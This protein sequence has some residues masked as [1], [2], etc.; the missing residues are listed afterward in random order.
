MKWAIMGRNNTMSCVGDG[1]RLVITNPNAS[2]SGNKKK[3]VEPTIEVSTLTSFD[4]LNSVDNDVEF[5]T[6]GR[7]TNLVNNG[8][9]SS[10]SFSMNIVNDV[11]FASNT[12]IGEKIDKTE[13]QI[14]EGKLRLLDNDGNPLVPTGIVKSDSK[15]EVIFDETANLRISTS[16][17][18]ESDKGYG[19]NSFL[20]Q[21]RDSYP[22]ND[23]YEPYDDDIT[24]SDDKEQK[25]GRKKNFKVYKAT[26]RSR[27]KTSEGTSKSPQT[28]CKS[29]T[30][31][32]NSGEGCL[33]SP[34]WTKAKITSDRVKQVC[35]FRLYAS[36]IVSIRQ[37][38]RAKQ[39]ALFNFKRGLKEH[40]GRLWEY[41]QDILDSNLGLDGYPSDFQELELRKGHEAYGVNIHLK[42]VCVGCG[43][44]VSAY[45][46]LNRDLV[47]G[48]DHWVKAQSENN[49]QVSRAGRMMTC[50]N[51]QNR[52]QQKSCKRESMPKPPKA[53]KA[54][55]LKHPYYET[56]ASAR[57]E[58]RGSGGRGGM[59]EWSGG[60]GESSAAM[61]EGNDGM[62]QRAGERAQR[63]RGRIK[64]VVERVKEAG[65]GAREVGEG[66]VVTMK[67]RCKMMREVEERLREQMEEEEW[68]MKHDYFHPS[69]W[70]QKESFDHAPFNRRFR[71]GDFEA[72][73]N[74]MS[75][76]DGNAD[77]GITC[78]QHIAAVSPSVDKG[79]QVAEPSEEAS[80]KPQTKK[81][82]S[83]RKASSAS[84]ELPLRIIYH[85]NRRRSRRVNTR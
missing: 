82:G 58:G 14:C 31:A 40:Y 67:T 64:E 48:V 6:N 57:G 76:A 26:T 34:K 54:P 20:E 17:K 8:A 12:R 79:K 18:D 70:T 24:K 55:V 61:G 11:E 32:G 2:F 84:K 51:C 85:K 78:A 52:V 3:S 19:T 43:G 36:W 22:D 65:E 5:G 72:K 77:L 74:Y 21:W 46:H 7:T 37:C 15:V 1:N 35:G 29:P 13:R 30:K 68:D 49:S 81:N 75:I 73:D 33:E 60:S 62:G 23:D 63:W 53:N 42:H 27:T 41:N 16:G 39:R 25:Q 71:L 69:N 28:T 66:M 45:N 9:T 50:T 44:L 47:E 38:K 4:V 56:Y 59:G 83:K 80:P 10:E